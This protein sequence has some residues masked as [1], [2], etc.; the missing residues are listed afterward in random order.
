MNEKKIFILLPDGNGLRNFIF[1]NFGNIIKNKCNVYIWNNSPVNLSV[2]GFNEV[3]MPSYK[4]GKFSEIL[5]VVKRNIELKLNKKY[6]RD[7]NYSLYLVRYNPEGL[8]SFIKKSI[9]IILNFLL[10]S[11]IGKKIID[12]LLDF[13]ES[14][15]SYYKNCYGILK[16]DQPDIIFCTNQR[17]LSCIAPILA[18][19]KL[20]ITTVTFIFS[21]DNI[22]K[23]TMVIR[24]DYYFVWSQY[25]KQELLNHYT[26][27]KENQI[28][29][30]GSPQFEHHFDKNLYI[31][32]EDFFEKYNL[33]PN[34]KY[35]CFSGNDITT[36][37]YDQ[38]YL[39]DL[40]IAIRQLNGQK[41]KIKIIFRRCPVD[42]SDRFDKV[43]NEFKDVIVNI[44]TLSTNIGSGWSSYVPNI[45]DIKLQTNIIRYSEFVVN[46]GSTM[47]LDF[48]CHNKLSIYINY[49][50]VKNDIRK[51]NI[52]K[53]YS[54]I[55]FKSMPSQDCVVWINSSSD[56]KTKIALILEAPDETLSNAQE[57]LKIVNSF[58]YKSA[59]VNV[60]KNINVIGKCSL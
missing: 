42:F 52:N 13:S 15:T 6:F 41:S 28:I 14:T 54:Y 2:M 23:A 48:I 35:L 36:S 30:T 9:Y 22:P 43:L 1:G 12:I 60:W 21:W 38:N 8:F 20:G 16:E 34:Y 24:T 39:E 19:K 25:M 55:H 3:K 4:S 17:P 57:W 27:V 47:A 10:T 50:N 29:V 51:W 49:N 33:N 59:S 11:K 5:K 44:K 18:A 40:A 32:K 7:N 37:P 53:I 56:Y 26:D 31:S 46:V 58:D 45:E